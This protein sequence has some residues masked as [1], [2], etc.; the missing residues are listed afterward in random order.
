MIRTRRQLKGW[1]PI[2]TLQLER[3]PASP[4]YK[5]RLRELGVTVIETQG[6]PEDGSAD[7]AEDENGLGDDD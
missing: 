4:R 6:E 3:T 2:R 1:S 5:A 7:E